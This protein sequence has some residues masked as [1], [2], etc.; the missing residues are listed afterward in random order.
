MSPAT[1]I[2]YNKPNL[3]YQISTH[4]ID[5]ESCKYYDEVEDHAAAGAERKG[6]GYY[7]H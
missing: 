2:I 1:D 3:L 5:K 6:N 7:Y 4:P